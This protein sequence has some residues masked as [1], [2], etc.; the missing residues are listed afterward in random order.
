MFF[1]NI[2]YNGGQYGYRKKSILKMQI[3][4]LATLIVT[5]VTIVSAL[6][7]VSKGAMYIQDK[8][9]ARANEKIEKSRTFL[10]SATGEKV[11][12]TLNE[13]IFILENKDTASLKNLLAEDELITVDRAIVPNLDRFIFSS[14]DALTHRE[15]LDK[16]KSYGLSSSPLFKKNLIN[17]IRE[18]LESQNILIEQ[19]ENGSLI[20]LSWKKHSSD[21]KAEEECVMRLRYLNNEL[22]IVALYTPTII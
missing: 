18:N 17:S 3:G 20:I 4:I 14:T 8:T 6:A 9:A 11:K 19:R 16:L 5:V 21:N 12:L 10:Q 13:F 22:K 1:N 15:L 7:L 2:K